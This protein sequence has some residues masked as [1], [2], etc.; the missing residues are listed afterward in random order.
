MSSVSKIQ[1]NIIPSPRSFRSNEP[2]SSSLNDFDILKKV[3]K[4]PSHD[5]PFEADYSFILI[6]NRMSLS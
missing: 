1:N 6:L 4:K 5:G 2:N 3:L